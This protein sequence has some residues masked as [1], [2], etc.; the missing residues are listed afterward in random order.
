M[1]KLKNL[2]ESTGRNFPN[3]SLKE[4]ILQN[5][6]VSISDWFYHGTPFGGLK[7]MLIN[8]IYGTDHGEIAEHDAFS[9]SLNSEM[10]TMFSEGDGETGLQFKV[11]NA[12]VV[13]LDDI[14]TYL[15]TQLP[16][17]GMDVEVDNEEKF[18]K[19]CQQFNIPT[20]GR[21][22]T[23]YLPY[24][25]LSS[26]GVDAF[27]YDYVWKRIDMGISPDVRDE[28]EIAFIGKGIE[29]LNKS[30]SGIWVDGHEYFP[31][32][33]ELALRDIEERI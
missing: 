4:Y 16:G 15:A 3:P 8:G 31:E 17:S 10:L 6:V 13:V 2:I 33:T 32:E 23:P 28:S 5:K 18:E 26:L 14:L 9:T 20:N 19:F 25:Y 27:I 30:V 22:N 24:N 29:K 11:K 1:I 12:Q 21:K 7:E